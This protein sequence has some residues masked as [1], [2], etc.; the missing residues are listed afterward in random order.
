MAR[1]SIQC[2]ATPLGPLPLVLSAPSRP[3]LTAELLRPGAEGIF[4]PTP[5][6]HSAGE[7]LQLVVQIK[8]ELLGTGLECKVKGATAN[9]PG[10]AAGLYVELSPEQQQKAK[11][12]LGLAPSAENPARGEVRVD[13]QLPVRLLAPQ[14]SDVFHTRNIS[15]S[16][17]LAT[18]GAQLQT[19]Q[20]VELALELNAN[21]TLRC[22][23]RVAWARPE[24]R[25]L[26]FKFDSLPADDL[27]RIDAL[28]AALQAPG[29]ATKPT[30]E[31]GAGAASATKAATEAA[32]RPDVLIADDE[33]SVAM[34]VQRVA[35]KLGL[36]AITFDRGDTALKAIR[37]QRP[38]LVMLDVL[39]PGLDGLQVCSLIRADAML[40]RT[41]VVLLSA[42]EGEKVK[43]IAEEARASAW[44][45]KPLDLNAV[46][47]LITDILKAGE[48]P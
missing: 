6:V 7:K 8:D 46:R 24:L 38:R 32:G 27:A 15:R 16:G 23:C 31:D 41:P 22:R 39:M 43:K 47:K 40:T 19:G 11:V 28:V 33:P 25:L 30:Q 1:P 26:G 35:L 44:L 48:A 18:C 37:A 14:L 34:F 9:G 12:F 21:D 10:G 29:P 13:C 3:L 5:E 42:L 17:M 2:F 45:Q 36:K 4:V 20:L